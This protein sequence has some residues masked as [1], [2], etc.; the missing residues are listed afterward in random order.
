VG[1]RVGLVAAAAAVLAGCGG[2]GGTAT[3]TNRP[4]TLAGCSS[5][6]FVTVGEL[7]PEAATVEVCVGTRCTE[8]PV[9]DGG[10]ALQLALPHIGG[11][12]PLTVVARV[13]DA[14][15]GVLVESSLRRRPTRVQPNGPGCRPICYRISARLGRDGRLAPR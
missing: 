10:F 6:V 4:C 13:R 5:G 9:T 8:G 15:G 2:S 3:R 14:G 7:P 12:R 1:R 11:G